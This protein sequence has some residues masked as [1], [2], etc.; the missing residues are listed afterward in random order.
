[1]VYGSFEISHSYFQPDYQY[2]L[3]ISPYLSSCLCSERDDMEKQL[4]NLQHQLS[5]GQADLE[6]LRS[7]SVDNQRQREL[8]RQQREDLERQLARERAEAERGYVVVQVRT[9]TS[10]AA[11]VCLQAISLTHVVLGGALHQARIALFT[12]AIKVEDILFY[13]FSEYELNL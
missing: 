9:S 4:S 8:L 7:S 2:L 13:Y 6:R 11:C 1:M 10:P 3:S 12:D 5:C